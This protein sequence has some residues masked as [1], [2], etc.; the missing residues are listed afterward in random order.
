[1]N[2]DNITEQAYPALRYTLLELARV[3]A[4]RAADEAATVPYWKPCPPS[5]QAHRIASDVLRAAADD[6]LLVR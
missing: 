3:E 6:F 1:M 5:V 4:D 2:A